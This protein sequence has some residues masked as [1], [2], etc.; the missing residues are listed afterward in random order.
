MSAFLTATNDQIG[1]SSEMPRYF[2]D[3]TENGSSVKD[4]EGS[5]LPTAE[6]AR[7][8][9]S[10]TITDMARDHIPGDGPQ[11]H[12]GIEVRDETGRIVVQ[13]SLSFD[14]TKVS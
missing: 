1:R 7:I 11:H 4:D 12:L 13:M 5:D 8:E 9:A 14:S 10:K 6:V 2:F 3:I